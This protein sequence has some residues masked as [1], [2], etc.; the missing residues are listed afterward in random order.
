MD[1]QRRQAVVTVVNAQYDE[2]ALL[3]ALE[4]RGYHGQV[5]KEGE[6]T[7][8]ASGA[9]LNSNDRVASAPVSTPR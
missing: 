1:F 2:Q 5:V 9:P 8:L 7:G 6:T 4:R 3:Q